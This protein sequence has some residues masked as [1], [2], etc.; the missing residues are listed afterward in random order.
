M[1]S[2]NFKIITHKSPDYRAAV[3]LREEILRKPLG[4]TFTCE[5]LEKEKDHIHIA[6]FIGTEVIATAVLVP[7]ET[8]FK[9][10]RVVVKEDLQNQG[11][12][13]SMLKFC[14]DYA[15]AHGY[16]EIYCHARDKAVPFYLK[17][18]YSPEG[19]YFD[20]NTISHLKM[21]KSL[22]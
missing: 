1:K 19:D 22:G 15:R 7:E 10:Q 3:F 6:G 21:R 4:L 9:M 14:E 2:I 5:E 11:I 17:N 18:N 20:E 8:I 12:A 13:S 16:K